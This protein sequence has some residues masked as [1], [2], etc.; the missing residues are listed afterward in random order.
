[1]QPNSRERKPSSCRALAHSETMCIPKWVDLGARRVFDTIRVADERCARISR[2]RIAPVCD[3]ALGIAGDMYGAG[4]S[5]GGWEVV[6]VIQSSADAYLI[7]IRGPIHERLTVRR[8]GGRWCI[9]EVESRCMCGRLG[10]ERT[11]G[12]GAACP[13]CHGVGWTRRSALRFRACRF[14]LGRQVARL[15]DRAAEAW[16]LVRSVLCKLGNGS[17]CGQTPHNG[18]WRPLPVGTSEGTQAL[19][20][21]HQ[22]LGAAREVQATMSAAHKSVMRRTLWRRM[23]RAGEWL[24][25][26]G[27]RVSQLHQSGSNVRVLLAAAGSERMR[28]VLGGGFPG[29]RIEGVQLRCYQCTLLGFRSWWSGCATCK[30]TKWVQFGG[31]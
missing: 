26:D 27:L 7:E 22:W 16:P 30:G 8:A 5:G 21:V 11:H 18:K 29:Y 6:S 3:P 19:A 1:M 14:R 10:S 2:Q 28:L 9:W 24:R 20:V 23:R 25:V 17:V 4:G 13:L 15:L 31:T 12:D